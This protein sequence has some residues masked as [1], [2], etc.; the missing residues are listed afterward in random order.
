MMTEANFDISELNSPLNIDNK[1]HLE[2]INQGIEY[3]E[4]FVKKV[5]QQL[6]NNACIIGDIYNL[7]EGLTQQLKGKL[8]ANRL[9]ETNELSSLLTKVKNVFNFRMVDGEQTPGSIFT[10]IHEWSLFEYNINE[11][12]AVMADNGI[13]AGDIIAL[14]DLSGLPLLLN[15]LAA[16]KIGCVFTLLSKQTET[17]FNTRKAMLKQSDPQ[18][19]GIKLYISESAIFDANDKLVDSF[20]EHSSE[21]HFIASNSVAGI[22][23]QYRAKDT[24][25]IN[26]DQESSQDCQPWWQSTESFYQSLLLNGLCLFGI[27]GNDN[28]QQARLFIPTACKFHYRIGLYLSALL[29][30]I[31]F[32]DERWPKNDINTGDITAQDSEF[33]KNAISADLSYVLFELSEAKKTKSYLILFDVWVSGSM[34]LTEKL[35]QQLVDTKNSSQNI[36]LLGFSSVLQGVTLMSRWQHQGQINTIFPVPGRAFSL[37]NALLVQQKTKMGPGLYTS[38]ISDLQSYASHDF[39]NKTTAGYV[40]QQWPMLKKQG[41]PYPTQSIAYSLIL[42]LRSDLPQWQWL[43]CC[44]VPAYLLPG[45]KV[46]MLFF[47]LMSYLPD[48]TQI[49]ADQETENLNKKISS[50]FELEGLTQYLPDQLDIFH[51]YPRA[52][53]QEKHDW[54][55]QQFLTNSLQ[56]KEHHDSFRLLS[57]LRKKFIDL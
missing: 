9:S 18:R 53:Q 16:I 45:G 29:Y 28:H 40:Y 56:N 36:R 15:V 50:W 44:F 5:Q 4:V 34:T 17:V 35:L 1:K 24:V 57:M 19:R 3:P 6:K 10:C 11:R 8:Q 23:H 33:K 2:I 43:D 38:R 31:A 49:K 21:K 52:E 22:S 20:T 55:H 42:Y 47:C 14:I 41:L 30:G 51:Y 27:K 48:K 32:E 13:T 46:Q 54:L 26:F 7:Y 12:A 37:N 25:C 39:L